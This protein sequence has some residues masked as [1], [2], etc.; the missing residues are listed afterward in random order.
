MSGPSYFANGTEGSAW[1]SVW[2]DVCVHGH[3][4]GPEHDPSVCLVP[5]PAYVG[6]AVPEWKMREGA[7]YVLPPDV[8]CTKFD[9]CTVGGCTGDP[10]PA[11]RASAIAR[12]EEAL[13][14]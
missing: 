8:I 7:P 12:V 9:P 6:E 2:C 3:G 1:E 5:V 10:Q 13:A 4:T 11:A 14:S